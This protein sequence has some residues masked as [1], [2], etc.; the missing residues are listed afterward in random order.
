MAKEDTTTM[1]KQAAKLVC[2]A[3]G[4]FTLAGCAGPLVKVEYHDSRPPLTGSAANEQ[5]RNNAG[6]VSMVSPY[7]SVLTQQPQREA[8]PVTRLPDVQEA[9]T[10]DGYAVQN[11]RVPNTGLTLAVA[12]KNGNAFACAPGD[13]MINSEVVPDRAISVTHAKTQCISLAQDQSGATRYNPVQLPDYYSRNGDSVATN[14]YS[15]NP[16]ESISGVQYLVN[17]RTYGRDEYL[18]RQ[19]RLPLAVLPDGR[20]CGQDIPVSVPD[21]PGRTVSYKTAACLKIT[22]NGASLSSPR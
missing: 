12:T 5:A 7:G 10:R 8:G 11:Y 21:H 16:Y 2:A 9:N 20:S 19:E 14:G 4:A 18:G 15:S 22:P 6:T 3:V 1:M 13:R 17:Q